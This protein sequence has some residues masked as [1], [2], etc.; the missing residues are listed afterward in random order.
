VF[1]PQPPILEMVPQMLF[2]SCLIKGRHKVEQNLSVSSQA[3]WAQM[4]GGPW[5][6]MVSPFNVKWRFSAQAGG[7]E[8]SKFCLF[9]VA[10]P[11]RCV[12]IVSPRFH[13][14]R[15]TFC[16]FPLAAILESPL[17]LFFKWSLMNY[18]SGLASNSNPP[19]LNFTSS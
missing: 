16:F 13:C 18:W 4:T 7:V 14:R 9:S 1:I 17:Y 10:F 11:A 12:S 19:N 2:C 8:G 15:H 3:I 5:A 6:L